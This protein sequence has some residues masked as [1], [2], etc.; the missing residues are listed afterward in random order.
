MY[1][2][3]F[4]GGP[5]GVFFFAGIAW[6]FVAASDVIP[7]LFGVLVTADAFWLE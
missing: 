1:F 2:Y 6:S 4:V 7:V 5:F 3:S